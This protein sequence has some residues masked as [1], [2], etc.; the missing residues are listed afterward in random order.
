[1]KPR[2]FIS[3][4][5]KDGVPDAPEPEPG[6]PAAR[7]AYA[8][9]VR[10][11]IQ[12]RLR[13]SYEV[14]L[15]K[16]DIQPGEDW[17]AK[18][19]DWLGTCDGAVILLDG[20]S[21]N[22]LW[23]QKE[24]TVV[25]W[26]RDSGS[27]VVVIP[28]FL[29]DFKA[30]DLDGTLLS[31]LNLPVSQA[32]RSE[33]R[34]MADGDAERLATQVRKSFC[35]LIEPL[36]E[37]PMEAWIAQV[38]ARV[39]EVN[40]DGLLAQAAEELGITREQWL[41]RRTGGAS[42]VAA[43]AQGLLTSEQVVIVQA[44]NKLRRGLKDDEFRQLWELVRPAWVDPSAAEHLR[45]AL[46]DDPRHLALLSAS[47]E[48]IVR[49][50]VDRAMWRGLENSQYLLIGLPTGTDPVEE[51]RAQLLETVVNREPT[52]DLVWPDDKE[53]VEDVIRAAKKERVAVFGPDPK[54]ELVAKIRDDYA[55]LEVVAFAG[56]E[57][58]G[59]LADKVDGTLVLPQ[60]TLEDEKAVRLIHSGLQL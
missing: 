7:L 52:L 5:S 44:L 13:D 22:S 15:D 37:T 25:A 12:A 32:A 36:A 38:R 23:V 29:G 19:D 3:H 55:P 40:D 6:T 30:E 8:R 35:D 33:T 21:V 43:I 9:K 2:I 17:E 58:V 18:L 60:L 53:E 27:G 28:V 11:L 59:A 54:P 20:E 41:Q 31:K 57:K 51:G 50:H 10:G 16:S 42:L 49:D 45:S 56:A 34:G 47:R 26:R 24:A 1:V 46:R 48:R 14:W 39:R 4:A